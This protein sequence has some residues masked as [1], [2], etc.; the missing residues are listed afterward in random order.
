MKS[1]YKKFDETMDALL[2]VPRSEIKAKLEAEKATKKRKPKTSAS[3]RAS[4]AKK[5]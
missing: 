1:E 4:R 3:V 2:K 5:V